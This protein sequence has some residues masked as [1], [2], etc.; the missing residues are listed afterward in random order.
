MTGEN[1][2]WPE[3]R[4]LVLSQ[5][6]ELCDRVSSLEKTIQEARL[7]DAQRIT[8]LEQGMATL[9]RIVYGAVAIAL[10]SFVTS[11]VRFVLK[12]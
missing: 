11:L 10:T 8:T 1:G 5:L 2:D 6:E 9:Q 3:N 7:E 4:K 12:P